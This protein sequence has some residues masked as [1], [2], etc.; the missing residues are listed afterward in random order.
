MASST[1]EVYVVIGAA[2]GIGAAVADVLAARGASLCLADVDKSGLDA[3]VARIALPERNVT[4]KLCDMGDRA[5]VRS[6]MDHAMEFFGKVDGCAN[7]GGISGKE[8]DKSVWDASSEEHDKIFAIN[9]KGIWNCMA[10]QLRPG[11]LG[12]GGSIVNVSSIE[13]FR[14]V[15][16][17]ASYSGSKHAVIGMTRSVAIEAGA[18]NIRVNTVAP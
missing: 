11:V 15:A 8:R 17:S 9:S 18:R 14:G 1:G 5:S 12:S 10:E 7:V 16:N 6:L 3:T 2:S 4:S 13:G